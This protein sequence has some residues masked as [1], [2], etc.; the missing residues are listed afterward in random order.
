MVT[1]TDLYR[2]HAPELH[3]FALRLSGQRAAAEDLVAEAFA[4]AI[5]GGGPAQPPSARAFLFGV[6]RN[7]AL[8]RRRDASRR[9]EASSAQ[10]ESALAGLAH[11]TDPE[12]DAAARAELTATLADLQALTEEPRAALLLRAEGLSYEEIAVVL[13]TSPGT[14]KV[15]VHR[16]RMS[17]AARRAAREGETP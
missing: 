1:V 11:G 5:A 10:A 13:G 12:R 17:L 14:A 15:R 4:L 9:P 8:H 3:R 16:A 6:V 7:L 2:R